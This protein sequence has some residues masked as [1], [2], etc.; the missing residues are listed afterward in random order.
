MGARRG[1]ASD[2]RVI[3]ACASAI[4]RAYT[5]DC[6]VRFVPIRPT[7]HPLY[8]SVTSSTIGSITLMMCV[9]DRTYSLSSSYDAELAELQAITITLH[10][11]R[12]RI[13]AIFIEYA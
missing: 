2:C 4:F 1:V 6:T 9:S 3:S 12:N 5:P 8:R 10:P 11:I 7:L 13:S